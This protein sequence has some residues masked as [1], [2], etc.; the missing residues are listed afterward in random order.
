MCLACALSP[1]AYALYGT[2]KYLTL[3]HA[4]LAA[5][6]VFGFAMG[7]RVAAAT[8]TTPS[9][10]PAEIDKQLTRWFYLAVV[11]TLLGYVAWFAVAVRNG[12]SLSLVADVILHP[13]AG[14]SFDL[15][16]EIFTTIPGLT[17]CVQFGIGAVLLGAWLW[18]RGNKHVVPWLVIVLAIAFVRAV[19]ASERLAL[20]ELI[21]PLAVVVLRMKFMGQAMRISRQ[22]LVRALPLL[23]IGGLLVF[24]GAA[25]YSRS[26]Q[27]YQDTFKTF[28]EYATWRLA[29]YYTT[30]LNNGAMALETREP[31]PIPYHSLHQFWSFPLIKRTPLAYDRLTGIEPGD[32]L[33]QMLTLHGTME[34][35]NE[36]GL[37]LPALDFGLFGFVIF[38]SC[39]GFLAGRLYRGFL[40]GSLGGT[41]L[42]PIVFVSLLDVPRVLYLPSSRTFPT[43]ALLLTI[44]VVHRSQIWMP[45]QTVARGRTTSR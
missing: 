36:G 19:V 4:A 11:L 15:K 16:E 3:W 20:L 28:P 6:A 29:G 21:V 42:Y 17:T 8:G 26:W 32:E 25:E 12:L 13:D 30:S 5:M 43:L 24:F 34:L 9:S 38:W 10:P 14:T 37:F 23:A 7:R 18:S 1:Y 35:N 33:E 22:W 44:L 45:A 41:L 31:L 40:A 2:Q 27:F 39:Y